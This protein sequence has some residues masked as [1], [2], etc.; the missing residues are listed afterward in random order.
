MRVL[1]LVSQIRQWQRVMLKLERRRQRNR[2][3]LNRGD[4][5]RERDRRAPDDGG[6]LV[7][8]DHRH[9]RIGPRFDDRQG[10]HGRSEQHRRI[11]LVPV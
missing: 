8:L 5:Q 10:K 11:C 9:R 4:A 7:D 2:I 6:A 3:A 1:K